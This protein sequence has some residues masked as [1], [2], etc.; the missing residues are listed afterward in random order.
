MVPRRQ[1]YKIPAEGNPDYWRDRARVVR[2]KADVAKDPRSK[3]MLGGIADA[4][5][6]LAQQLEGDAE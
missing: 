2:L 3:R 4:Y 5:D 6:R 1:V